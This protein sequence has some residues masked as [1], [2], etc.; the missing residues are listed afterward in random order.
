MKKIRKPTYQELVIYII[1]STLATFIRLFTEN[2]L[3]VFIVSVIIGVIIVVG[4][5]TIKSNHNT[6]K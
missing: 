1:G 2:E 6:N 5:N 3:V 4:Y